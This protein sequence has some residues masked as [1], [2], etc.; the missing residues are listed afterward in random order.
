M[1]QKK[2]ILAAKIETTIGTA[3]ALGNGDC[4]F[5][6]YD[7]IIQATPTFNGRSQTGFFGPTKGAVGARTGT[8]TFKT[9]L[10]GD[11]AGGVPAWGA[12]FLPA[13][14]W[15]NSAGT[16]SPITA[17]P[18]AAGGVKTLTMA[19]YQDGRIKSLRGCMGSWRIVGAPG[20]LLQMEWTFMGAFADVVDGASLTPT[21]PT[22]PP[23]R[24]AGGSISI[25]GWSPC[26]SSLTIES[27]NDVQAVPCQTPTDKSGIKHYVVAGRTTTLTFDPES[28]LVATANADVYGD[29]LDGETDTFSL[30]LA[31]D[32]DTITF[33]GPAL[34]RTN[35]QE[36][37]RQG[38]EVDTVTAQF[39]RSVGDDNFTIAFSATP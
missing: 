11:G 26:Y 9:D 13:C 14:G 4:G 29:W 36:G 31:D 22:P 7:P 5:V 39:N 35:V 32:D 10:T 1:L 8:L 12:T 34:Q 21:Y 2:R 24:L 15:V 19:T 25:G 30:V 38:L 17:G 33:T 37:V 20:D 23:F 18:T 16:F 3:I 27:G 6:V 28:S